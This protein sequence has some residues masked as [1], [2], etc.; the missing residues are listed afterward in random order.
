MS[1]SV[2]ES[3]TLHRSKTP[4]SG[5]PLR[6]RTSLPRSLLGRLRLAALILASI[7]AVAMVPQIAGA[8][9][10]L[11]VRLLAIAVAFVLPAYWAW[12]VRRGAFPLAGEPLEVLALYLLLRAT[13]GNPILPLTGLILR[14][15]YGSPALGWIRYA[16]WMGALIFAHAPRGSHQLTEDMAR[17]GA[18]ALVPGFLQIL[19]ASLERLETSE[20]RL[21]SLVQNSTDVVTV[22]DSELRIRW[23]ADSIGAV[24]GVDARDLLGTSLLE[25]IAPSDWKKLTGFIADSLEDHDLTR[26]FSMMLR[27]GDGTYRNFEVVI[28]DRLHDRSVG[29]YVLNMR[30]A[31]DRLRLEQDLRE[32]A[33]ERQHDAMHDP[34]TGLANRRSLLQTLERSLADARDSGERMALLLIDLDRFKELNDT[35]GHQVGDELLREMRPRLTVAARDAAVVARLGGDEFAV[36]LADP[37]TDP[38][39]IAERLKAALERPFRYQGLTLLVEASVGIALYPD[40]GDDAETLLQRADIAMYTAKR[41][42]LGHAVYDP[43]QDDYSRDRLAL[44]GELP[45]AIAADQLLIHYQPKF[46][47]VTGEIRGAEA[48]VRWQHPERGLLYPAAFLPVVEQ[49]GLMRPLTLNV[50]EQGLAQ[51]AR[52]RSEGIHIPVAINLAAANLLDLALADDIDRLLERYDLDSSM[53]ELEITERIMAA[54][55]VRINKVLDEFAARGIVLALDDFGTGSSS[56][57]YLRQLPV[58]ELKID[59]SFVDGSASGDERDAAVIRTII[60]LAQDLGLRSV[61]EGIETDEMRVQL[62][63]WGCEQG[64]G[65]GLARPAPAEVITRLAR[66]G[67]LAPAAVGA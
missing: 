66:S 11:G 47:L 46:D 1:L 22:V 13:P 49:T 58:Q 59:K 67:P 23:Q 27:H 48:L 37:Q 54:D 44:L 50:L 19:R 5:L 30:D 53:L 64:Q 32:L 52:W 8:D 12:C 41:R 55:P 56:L 29:G 6:R 9:Q 21:A 25:L 63:A 57:S 14:S 18:M 51:C 42:R 36:V 38:I 35:L 39:E 4:T 40:H 17:I 26:T 65:F 15:M 3:V 20:R 60:R 34:L 7:S 33:A 43:G 28:A 2:L 45:P 24:L 31:T 61:A 10:P 16:A 62:T